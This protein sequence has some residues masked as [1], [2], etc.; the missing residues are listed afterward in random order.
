MHASIDAALWRSQSVGQRVK[1]NRCSK[2][3]A[4][5]H[6]LAAWRTLRLSNHVQT[7]ARPCASS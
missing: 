5:R 4:R 7:E 1:P 6:W 2:D 3:I